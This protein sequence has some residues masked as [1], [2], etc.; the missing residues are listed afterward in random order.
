VFFFGCEGLSVSNRQRPW[1][2]PCTKS[3]TATEKRTANFVAM[4]LEYPVR[5]DE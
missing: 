3:R 2:G 5:E 4:Q 1:T